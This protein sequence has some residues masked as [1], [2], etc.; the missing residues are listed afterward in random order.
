[1]QIDHTLEKEGEGDTELTNKRYWTQCK[2]LPVKENI[3]V[4]PKPN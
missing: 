4:A 1:M 3:K 2:I